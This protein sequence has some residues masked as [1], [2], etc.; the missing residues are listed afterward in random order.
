[1]KKRQAKKI[2]LR[3]AITGNQPKIY[4]E[5][6][7]TKAYNITDPIKDRNP[8]KGLVTSFDSP[9]MTIDYSTNPLPDSLVAGETNRYSMPSGKYR[10]IKSNNS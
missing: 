4:T 9:G 10:Y 8:I 7:I 6:Q 5:Y 2:M 3:Y 1:M